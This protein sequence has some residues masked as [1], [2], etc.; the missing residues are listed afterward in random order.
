MKY[1]PL[2]FTLAATSLVLT[3]QFVQAEI[4][5]TNIEVSKD[6]ENATK[7]L[8]IASGYSCKKIDALIQRYNGDYR[9]VC[10]GWKYTYDIEDKGGTY[11]VTLND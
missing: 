10:N 5:Q 2:M 7:A 3:S 11:I 4:E 9:V 6:M 8:I 1:L